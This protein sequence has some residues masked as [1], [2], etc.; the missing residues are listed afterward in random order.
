[1]VSAL[2]P[3]SSGSGSSPGRAGGHCV[4]GKTLESK[5]SCPRTQHSAT[6]CLPPPWSINGYRPL[7]ATETRI[8]SGPMSQSWLQGFTSLFTYLFKMFVVFG[9]LFVYKTTMQLSV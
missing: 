6:Q 4:L 1:M 2:V 7:H 9:F 8:S 3:G 5:V